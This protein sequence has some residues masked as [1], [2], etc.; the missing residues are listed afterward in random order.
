VSIPSI[1]LGT[2]VVAARPEN[3]NELLVRFQGGEPRRLTLEPHLFRELA[4][5]GFLTAVVGWHLP[6]CRIFGD[7]LASCFSQPRRDPQPRQDSVTA[8]MLKQVQSLFYLLERNEHIVEYETLMERARA[9]AA[10]PEFDFVYL[11]LP[12]PHGPPIYDRDSQQ[13]SIARFSREWYLDNLALADRALG[14]LRTS[15]EAA[16]VWD[17]SAVVLTSDHVWLLAHKFVGSA[18]THVPFLVRVPGSEGMRYGA[19]TSAV[20][21]H[22]VVKALLSGEAKSTLDVAR[23]V[24]VSD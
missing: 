15:M 21:A 5:K 19:E 17:R 7:D 4:A 12:V 20:S 3:A 13:M 24:E 22:E 2:A 16:G 14:E 10:D 9:A 18:D 8:A 11:H 1:L 23:T 6:Y